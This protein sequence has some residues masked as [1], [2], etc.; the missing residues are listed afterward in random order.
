[1]KYKNDDARPG[2]ELKQITT[3]IEIK[4]DDSSKNGGFEGY[5]A[6]FGNEDSYGEVINPG[7]FT[8]TIAERKG[9]IK[10]LWNHDIRGLP[11]GKPT[12]L[13]ED[14]SGL[15]VKADF[16]STTL[17]QDVRALMSDGIID[18]MSIGFSTVKSAWEELND[19]Y[20][21]RLLE[22]K[23]YE[24]SPVNI[25]ANPLAQITGTKAAADVIENALAQ[26]DK[27]AQAGLKSGRGLSG[28]NVARL[29]DAY[30]MLGALLAEAPA[31]AEEKTDDALVSALSGFSLFGSDEAKSEAAKATD[32]ISR[33]LANI[34]LK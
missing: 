12:D 5:A 9:Q 21:R 33:V 16:A 20:V 23:L 14:E 29:Q 13:A 22:I 6:F 32:E 7:A 18:S 28:E 27:F 24:F 31:P 3:K 17:A 26:L 34:N 8:K 19:N 4:A 11:I 10:V 1:M 30:R 2:I 25:P 15:Y